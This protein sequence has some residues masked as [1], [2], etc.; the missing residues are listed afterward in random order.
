MAN[1]E[2][3]D[4]IA[5]FLT[6]MN[7]VLVGH[8]MMHSEHRQ[9]MVRIARKLVEK[10]NVG[11]VEP[12]ELKS[13]SVIETIV[14]IPHNNDSENI[15]TPKPGKKES[16]KHNDNKQLVHI[17]AETTRSR[18]ESVRSE[19]PYFVRGSN[20]ATSDRV[21]QRVT[22]KAGTDTK[23]KSDEDT[24]IHTEKVYFATKGG[25]LKALSE[26][27]KQLNDNPQMPRADPMKIAFRLATNSDP[28]V[29]VKFYLDDIKA[30]GKIYDMHKDKVREVYFMSDDEFNG[31]FM[32][33]TASRRQYPSYTSVPTRARMF[34][35]CVNNNKFSDCQKVAK[36]DV[37]SYMNGERAWHDAYEY[38]SHKCAACAYRE[39]Y[40]EDKNYD[41]E[42]E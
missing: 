21:S 23:K 24:L 15:S 2:L 14:E 26:V 4:R 12:K 1:S 33:K 29:K 25:W 30:F 41:D 18:D 10:F 22:S 39:K 27:A 17:I 16:P 32:L 5:D 36:I 11:H 31:I 6:D 37:E 40:A 13:P 9:A 35:P 7:L 3:Y 28:L 8:P 38:E 42:T 20:G 34:A 19:Q